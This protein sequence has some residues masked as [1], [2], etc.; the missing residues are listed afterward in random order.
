MESDHQ[1]RKRLNLTENT[2][3]DQ[4]AKKV[5]IPDNMNSLISGGS[6]DTL[7]S[8]SFSFPEI[9]RGSFKVR[10]EDSEWKE[11]TMPLSKLSTRIK[12]NSKLVQTGDVLHFASDQP[13]TIYP[14]V[15]N[16]L[17][18]TIYQAYSKHIPLILR[19]DDIWIAIC[20]AF[21]KYVNKNAQEMRSCFVEHAGRKQLEIK[22]MSPF[23]EFTTENHWC[24]FVKEMEKKIA[25]NVKGEVSKWMVP[26]FSTTTFKDRAV[27]TVVLM[28]ALKEYFSYVGYCCCGLSQV[29]LMGSLADWTNLVEKA[30]H[31]YTFNQKTLSA[32]ADLL[33]P[34]LEQFVDAYN[35]NVDRNFWERICTNKRV[36][37]GGNV[38][39][40]GWFMVF[41][42]FDANGKYILRSKEAIDYDHMYADILDSAIPDCLIECPFIVEDH[43][44]ECGQYANVSGKRYNVNFIAGM[45]STCYNE[46]SNTIYPSVDWALVIKKPI[47]FN[48]MMDKLKTKWDNSSWQRKNNLPN[49]TARL[50][51]FAFY[52]AKRFN[53]PNDSL[54]ELVEAVVRYY[55]SGN[56]YDVGHPAGLKTDAEIH[57]GFLRFINRKN[58]EGRAFINYLE[59]VNGY[60]DDIVDEYER[61]ER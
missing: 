28:G 16:G 52:A 38:Q 30:K 32:W 8:S 26:N 11:N 27:G 45:M 50:L 29:T 21:G 59:S 36:G 40:R 47:T 60:F 43:T 14:Y 15:A 41:S 46:Q 49:G 7:Q 5:A 19:P 31:L 39:F 13:N 48:D 61:G 37:S 9:E 42:P 1:Q 58:Y 35:G 12:N 2:M 24:G 57:K 18:S 22:V 3:K 10:P 6:L 20:V 25:E 4:L 53:F 55:S 17:M 33:I 34:V 54:L 51:P 23:M 56:S 44:D